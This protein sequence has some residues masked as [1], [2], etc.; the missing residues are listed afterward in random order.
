ML[1]LLIE[2]L[3]E[4]SEL[5]WIAQLLCIDL[6]VVG[7][8]VST[9]GRFIIRVRPFAPRLRAT[10]PVIPFGH[11]SLFL[12]LRPVIVGGFTLHFLG[13]GAEHRVLFGL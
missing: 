9:I 5:V 6:F 7:A 12:G 10:R 4:T 2:L 13:L 8:S 11:G 3:A 1:Q